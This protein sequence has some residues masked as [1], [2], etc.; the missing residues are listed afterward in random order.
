MRRGFV[1]LGL[2]ACALTLAV[3]AHKTLAR[4]HAAPCSPPVA[5]HEPVDPIDAARD[6]LA[7]FE[8]QRRQATDFARL[9]PANLAHGADPYALAQL[10][11]DHFVGVL[12]G[13]S[14]LVV[15]DRNLRELTRAVV[16]ESAVTVAVTHA[17]EFWVG[18]ELSP[19]LTRY[20]FDGSRLIP[21]ES[22][23]VPQIFGIRA[24][25]AGPRGAFYALDV[26]D[27]RLLTLRPRGKADFEASS[28]VVGHGPISL[29]RV[30]SFLIV[31][32]FLDHCLIVY[33]LN[34]RGD[35]EGERARIT[36]DGPIWGFD[37]ALTARGELALSATGVEDHPLDRSDGSFGNI[38]SFAF[39]YLLPR[40]GDAKLLWSANTSELGVV[41]PKAPLLRLDGDTAHLFVPGYGSDHAVEF[42]FELH[43]SAAP[44]KTIEPF[45]PGAS[46]ALDL[47]LGRFGFADPLLDAW[48]L[49]QTNDP[50]DP[51]IQM[52]P[53]E[54][55]PTPRAPKDE[56]IG[57]ALFFTTLMAPGNS[58]EGKHSR[59]TC[60]TCHFEG[61]VD[62]RVHHTGRGDVRVSTKPL[63]GL[64]NNRP[65][66]SRALD[67]DLA[68]V[69]QHE[70]RVAGLGNGK[71]AW[72]SLRVEDFPWL[73]ALGASDAELDPESL[74]RDLIAFLMGFSHT[75]NPAVA[76]RSS[77]SDSERR[78]AVL[79]RDHCARC[80][81]AR[82]STDVPASAV[83]FE[84][85]EA[86][87]FSREGALVWASAEYQKTG[88][89]PYVHELGARTPSLRR[90][91]AKWPHFTNGSAGSVAA[92]LSR[93]RFDGA[94]FF[95]DNAPADPALNALSESEA[96]DLGAFLDLL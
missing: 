70:F 91:Y 64:F 45:S 17:D 9:P 75:T 1:A 82:F 26:H 32:A 55:E 44:A 47:G 21:L 79:F 39:Q 40:S 95:H 69:A 88:V 15:L 89:T 71:D 38:D 11:D 68:S 59:F 42:S 93:A 7:E 94:R 74:R 81:A 24:L 92:V 41:T 46:A 20:R 86:A 10:D 18:G 12:R 35:I 37:A 14:M 33:R 6:R 43:S 52:R 36:H 5:S 4:A 72:F 60:E 31:N 54:A 73:A 23:K 27:G 13:A 16:P 87:I 34:A 3:V 77:F 63:R 53:V 8:R 83:P 30:G 22:R 96:R 80:H 19:A 61:Y 84:A 58:S 48:L 28:R 66:F 57:E 78:G 49:R 51:K 62:G 85:W 56:R 29:R 65:H 50:L 67:A 25:S 76:L 90:L 2:S